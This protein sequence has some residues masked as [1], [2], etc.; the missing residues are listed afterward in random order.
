MRNADLTTFIASWSVPSPCCRMRR[1][2]F[3]CGRYT[4]RP[5]AGS[6]SASRC[7]GDKDHE[8][9]RSWYTWPGPAIARDGVRYAGQYA[10]RRCHEGTPVVCRS[11][12]EL[13]STDVAPW[14]TRP[15]KSWGPLH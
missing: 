7:S 10:L 8:A 12:S 15:L 1:G 11:V 9:E 6:G 4:T 3:W 14:T 5:V 2:P 13:V